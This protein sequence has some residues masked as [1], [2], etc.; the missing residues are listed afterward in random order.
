MKETVKSRGELETVKKCRGRTRAA[1]Y[2]FLFF[3]SFNLEAFF[4]LLRVTDWPLP[5]CSFGV[6]L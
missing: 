6:S 2:L 4:L 5:D 1:V 3:A